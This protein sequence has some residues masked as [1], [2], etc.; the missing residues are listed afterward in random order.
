[1]GWVEESD[2]RLELIRSGRLETSLHGYSRPL[3]MASDIWLIRPYMRMYMLAT[4]MFRINIEIPSVV[5]Y[6]GGTLGHAFWTKSG[7]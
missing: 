6:A 3:I 1:M 7:R 4:N 2:A 5:C